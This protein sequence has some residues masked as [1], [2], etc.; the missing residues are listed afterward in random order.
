M[1]VVSILGRKKK[2]NYVVYIAITHGRNTRKYI[3]LGLKVSSKYW[4]PN[5][6]EVRKNHKNHVKLNRLIGD[7][8]TRARQVIDEMVG[9]RKLITIDLL[10][11]NIRQALFATEEKPTGED[12]I[13][14]CDRRLQEYRDRDQIATFKAYRTAVNKL[15]RFTATKLKRSTLPFELVSVDFIRAF[16]THLIKDLKNAPNTVHKNLTSIRT[17]LYEAIREGHMSR[18]DDPFFNIRIR[19]ENT[20]RDRIT[21]E[22]FQAI[23]ALELEE[24]TG[25]WDTRNEFLFAFYAGGMRYSDICLYKW[26]YVRFDGADYRSR[27]KMKKVS[28]GAGVVL[29]PKAIEILK[30]YGD[31]DEMVGKNEFVFYPL[32]S[33]KRA[34]T[35][36]QIFNA[37]NSANVI[38]NKNLGKIGERAGITTHLTTHMARHSIAKLL[39]ELGWDIYDI[40][41]VL[42]HSKVSTTQQYLRGFQSRRLDSD[43]RSVFE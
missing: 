29:V 4:N 23:E 22:E 11:D 17:L 43:Y 1:A 15:R 16:H 24:G 3:S 18:N 20:M 19:K 7:S 12:F 42:G 36:A 39:D 10:Q 41:K 37:I 5:T 28:D 9:A 34:K 38:A 27:F 2:N 6:N 35:E 33:R 25:V 26:S 13:E 8:L 14:F 30:L 32:R 31:L 21:P 40:M